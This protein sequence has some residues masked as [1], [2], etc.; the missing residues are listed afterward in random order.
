MI[1]VTA[2]TKGQVVIPASLRK[3]LKIGKGTKL[4]VCEKDGTIVME[5]VPEDPI[6]TGRGMLPT[7]GRVLKRLVE[8]RKEE[9][10]R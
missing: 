5:V 9:S 3:R 4:T 8:D 7:R 10:A 1:T 6:K 2:T